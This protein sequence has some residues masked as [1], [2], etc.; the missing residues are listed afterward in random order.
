[1]NPPSSDPSLPRRALHHRD[2]R[3]F[4]S[5]RFLALVSHQMINVAMGQYI[6]ELT[7][8]PLYL[9]YIGLALFLPKIAFVLVSGHTA[10]RYD[11]KRVI[12]ICRLIQFVAAI[13]LVIAL[14]FDSSTQLWQLF[15]LLFLIG[16]ANAFDGPASQSIV[17]QLV[18]LA[19]L[20]DAVTWST[21][22]VQFSFI[23]GPAAAGWIYAAGNR[24]VDVLYVVVAM[25]LASMLLV[26]LIRSRTEQLDKSEISWKTLVAGIRY[27]FEKR[28]ILGAI[29]L[30]LFAVLLGGAIA[31]MPIYA[32]EIL[33]VG[34]SGLGIL[35]A[36]PAVGAGFTAL[37]LAY[38]PPL[39]RA[40]NTMFLCVALFGI[41]TILFGISTN[42]LFSLF[43]LFIL[44]AADM[45]SVVIRGVLVQIKTP[46]VMRGRVSAVNIVFIG[47][48]NEL[49]EFESGL[50]AAW[51]G[52]VPSVVIGGLGTL[53]VVGVWA[54][55]FPELRRY[56]KMEDAS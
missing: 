53:A 26:T 17:P 3:Y 39:K 23:V 2:F 4:V 51:F 25:R 21:S 55:R 43:C 47:A 18:P 20:K 36:A 31:L 50:T 41:F 19:H 32:N 8:N 49:G 27:V 28:V 45:V 44:G 9:G 15:T 54:W 13:G 33:K 10:D 14:L 34:P 38:L 22:A 52:V 16:V 30:D 35:R 1:M 7:H 6:W 11:R 48:S 46:P 5:A 29:S 42:F 37:A 12:L 24:A 40:G 56:K